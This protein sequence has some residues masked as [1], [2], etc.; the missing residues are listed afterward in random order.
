IA[1]QLPGLQNSA[2]VKKILGKTATLEFRMV[3]E[4]S[5]PLEA[6]ATGHVPLG[7]KLYYTRDKQP[8]LLKREVVVTGDQLTDA[9][10]QPNTQE[11]AAVSVGLDSR[12][13]AKMLKNTQENIGHLMAVVF[14]DRS[15]EKNA[16]GQD[17][18]RTTEEVINRATIRGVFS[19]NF[20]ITGVNPIE[21]REL[22]LL[23]RAGGLAAPLTPVEER[24]IGPSLGQDNITKGVNA[25]VF[26][27][28]AAFVF[29][30]I[31]YK[32]FG[33]IADVVLIAN[34]VLLTAFLSLV[35]AALTLPGI[36]AVVLTVG[37][38][39][40]ANIL[41]FERMR[42]EL[43]LGK[44]LATA[45]QSGY[46]KALWTILD[47]HAVQLIICCIMIG[48]GTGPIK[49]FGVTLAIG[50]LST[51]FSVLITSHLVMELIIESGFVKNFRM[52]R[53]LKDIKVDFIRYGKPAFIGS[54]LIVIIGFGYVLYQGP[55]I[56]GIDFAGGDM[57][58][59]QFKQQPDA[60]KIREIAKANGV[61]DLNVTSVSSIGGGGQ[62]L[63]IETPEGKGD[64]V[65]DALQK[66]L[67]EDGLEKIGESHIGASIGKEIELNALLA[68][69]VSMATILVY[70]A[71]RFEFGFGVGAMFSSLH[72]ILMTIGIFVLTGHQFSAPM[73]AAILCIAG[74]SI[75][76]TVVVF[77]RIRE[78][79]KLNPNGSLR[80][81]VNAAI[82]KV[83]ARTIMTAT[84]TFL[85]A[86]ALFLFGGGVLRD[87][88]F[89]FLVGI[90]TS[91][92]SAIFIA[93]Q[94]FY[95]W[96]KGDRKHV[97]AHSDIAP[98]YEWQGASRASR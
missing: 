79:L 57:I 92:F 59:V 95:W 81:V 33:L 88:S 45:N 40:D 98:K 25:M 36:A 72:D 61:S 31:Y 90:V 19:N 22:A 75:N 32:V 71:F 60:A 44:S 30:A 15:R 96:H 6:A 46:L 62:A 66:A 13:A 16:Q 38:A 21:G 27:M 94:V 5:N 64:V 9:S 80:D 8:V 10:F 12:G 51:L 4:N 49:G 56:Y 69:G 55:Q 82:Q 48:L 35:G 54:W 37:M 70:I 2:E 7:S 74:Y 53:L 68:V 23:L 89:T 83:F 20:Q 43:A 77:D 14:I 42:E 47:A 58:N 3:D 78:E 63:N 28:L 34:V 50:V 85:A 87:I 86:L 93:S 67:P 1:I 17:V 73:V 91:T 76:E 24:A 39:V 26:G 29:M 97:E 18:D 41:I 11:G 52:N 65:F 84:T